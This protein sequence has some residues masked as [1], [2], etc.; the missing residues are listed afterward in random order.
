PA[1]SSASSSPGRSPKT[2]RLGREP[3]NPPVQRRQ[4]NIEP[5]RL[6][7]QPSIGSETYR[8]P[9]VFD[10]A[11]HGRADPLGLDIEDLLQARDALVGR[12]LDKDIVAIGRRRQDFDY[13]D[14]V[15]D[16]AA[17]IAF[18]RGAADHEVGLEMVSPLQSLGSDPRL[19]PHNAFR[20]GRPQ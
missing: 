9:T 16:N 1:I 19:R 8:L 6:E 12:E 18:E 13:Q 20:S 7:L 2:E 15:G 14:G 10:A 17:N 5:D 4:P 11:I 3:R